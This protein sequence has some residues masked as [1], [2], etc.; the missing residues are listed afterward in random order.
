[1]ASTRPDR[2]YGGVAN[3]QETRTLT[4]LTLTRT[5]T[6]TLTLALTLTLTLTLTPTLLLG[7][8]ALHAP[9][10]RRG[11]AEQPCARD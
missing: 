5:L 3:A 7:D 11:H 8:P 2:V 1:M 9:P 6:R 4:P 10:P